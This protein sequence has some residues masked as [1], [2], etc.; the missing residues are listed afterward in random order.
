MKSR[1]NPH[2]VLRWDRYLGRL[3][4]HSL[5]LLCVRI[6]IIT[7]RACFETNSRMVGLSPDVCSGAPPE[8]PD[9]NCR[10]PMAE[11]ITAQMAVRINSTSTTGHRGMNF[12]Y[13]IAPSGIRRV[14]TAPM[15]RRRRATGIAKITGRN[16]G[17]LTHLARKRGKA[18][19]T[20]V[21]CRSAA[22]TSP[23][24]APLGQYL[25]QSLHWWQS[26][27]SGSLV[28]WSLSPHWAHIISFLG[29]GRSSGER[30]HTTEQA[31]H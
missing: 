16:L 24:L 28:R 7:G 8:N 17:S 1:M 12:V 10:M 22:R 19:S 15:N 13:T 30:L 25:E 11:Q 18:F 9:Q 20:I 5:K 29:K 31:A 26:H 3:T 2:I 14:P 6:S 4:T 23:G 27:T 21:I